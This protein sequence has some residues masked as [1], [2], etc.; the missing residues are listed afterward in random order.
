MEIQRIHVAEDAVAGQNEVIRAEAVLTVLLGLQDQVKLRQVRAALEGVVGNGADERRRVLARGAARVFVEPYFLQV[1]PVCEGVLAK[2]GHA[3]RCVG[4]AVVVVA[5]VD[6]AVAKKV[7]V[8]R[9][10]I[11]VVND[12]L[13]RM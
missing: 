2:S 3:A 7:P 4:I 1:R 9:L 6:D 11:G 12:V 13:L 10:H 5:H 8:K